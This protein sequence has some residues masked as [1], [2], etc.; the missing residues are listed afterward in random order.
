MSEDGHF[1]FAMYLDRILSCRREKSVEY[2]YHTVVS[3]SKSL[4]HGSKHLYQS[5]PRM[6][7]IWL[8]VGSQVAG[9]RVPPDKVAAYTEKLQLMNRLMGELCN[10]LKLYQLMTALPQLISRICHSHPGVFEQIAEIVST[11][12]ATYP[13]QTMWHMLAVSKSSYNTRVLRCQEIL[14]GAKRKKPGLNKFM[15]DITK[16]ADRFIELSNKQVID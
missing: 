10:S 5:L 2:Q 6:L 8:E 3:L 16:L 14:Q 7:T 9:N 11:L 13:Q 1:H 15:N 4:S 12:L